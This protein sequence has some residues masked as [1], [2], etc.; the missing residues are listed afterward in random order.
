MGRDLA[1]I[2]SDHTLRYALAQSKVAGQSVLDAACGCGYGSW[3]LAEDC[4]QVHA[5]DN[6]LE[7]ISYGREHWARENVTYH[8]LDL[9]ESPLPA[10]EALV[11]F[12][13]LEHLD[14][15]RRFLTRARETCKFLIGSV[16]NQDVLPF[17]SKRHKY[18]KRHY[19]PEQLMETLS[20]SGWGLISLLFQSRETGKIY[21]SAG[22]YIIFTARSR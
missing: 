19:T 15:P 21:A 16:P 8:Q 14:Y 17:D 13:T 7:A 5:V 2:R 18:H 11:S 12:E 1:E 22:D 3:M 20:R 4:P 10:A 9:C 6:S